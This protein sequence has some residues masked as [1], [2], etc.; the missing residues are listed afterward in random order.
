MIR[1]EVLKNMGFR[2]VGFRFQYEIQRRLGLLKYKFP[3]DF[4]PS[5]IDVR[6]MFLKN[7]FLTSDIVPNIE[8]NN[9]TLRKEAQKIIDNKILYFSSQWSDMSKDGEYFDWF[10]NPDSKYRYDS[11]KHWCEIEDLS[12]E[13][14]DIKYVWEASRFSWVFTLLRDQVWNNVDHSDFLLKHIEDWIDNNKNNCGP[15]YKC[16]Q[17]ISLRCLNW[18]YVVSFYKDNNNFCEE[19]R[20]KII[21]SIEAQITHVFQNINFSRIAVRNNHAITE[22]LALY[23][24]GTLFKGSKE[25]CKWREKGKKW[26]EEEVLYQIYEDGS[27]LQFSM[28][29]HRVVV[30]LLT[31]AISFSESVDDSFSS[32]FYDR[33]ISTYNFLIDFCNK[34]NGRLPNHGSNDGALF[35]PLNSDD[36]RDYRGSL[37]AFATVLNQPYPFADY[38]CEDIL[39]FGKNENKISLNDSL[40]LR[41][42]PIGGY[43]LIK[44]RSN[45]T[46]L[47]C[48]SYK[49]R[50]CQSDGLHL[51]IFV[52][53]HNILLDAGSY[54]YNTGEEEI[55]YFNGSKG[56][57]CASFLDFDQ[58]L[59]GPRFIWYNWISS[60]KCDTYEDDDFYIL[61]GEIVGYK[62]LN[63]EG[64]IQRRNVVKRKNIN[65]WIVKDSFSDTLGKDIV[66]YWRINPEFKNC[67]K[68]ESFDINNHPI[69]GIW[70]QGWQ[71]DYYGVKYEIP[72]YKLQTKSSVITTKIKIDV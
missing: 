59:K 10:L 7:I 9:S 46:F 44:E 28:N 40:G 30:Q 19:K 54:K 27:Y 62:H 23:V 25:A 22:C 51:D 16:S 68:I 47:R 67:L 69:K 13:K 15:H 72:V 41:S 70:E 57:N 52:N 55:L 6:K 48:G 11:K 53:G 33:C 60:A 45:Q 31:F 61:N 64:I 43:Y 65:E 50:P 4:S 21:S 17:E 12:K 49:D 56:H 35:F 18:M 37:S 71:S 20:T 14:G 26:L 34:N 32:K 42:Y 3:V 66:V 63:K 58:M 1:F 8:V 39:W 2:Y 5:Q 38:C 36:Y 29:Y 24:F